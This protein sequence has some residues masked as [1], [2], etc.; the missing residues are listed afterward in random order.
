MK[1]PV[2]AILP[3]RNEP[4]TIA[5]VT[6]AVDA[7]LDDERAVIV[8]A[9]SSDAPDTAEAF[10]AVPTRARTVALTGLPRGKGTQIRHAV[11]RVRPPGAVL[12]ADTDTR[13]PD[14]QVYRALVN[15][16]CTGDGC[17]I[18]DYPRHWYEGNLTSHLAR[19]LIAAVTGLD[20]PQPLAG[21][22][23]LS[24]AAVSAV[25]R[26]VNGL[27]PP[28]SQCV[29]GYGID[30][31]LLLSV[32]AAGESV[33]PVRLSRPKE[34]APSF[35]HLP[36]IFSQ[37]VPVLLSLTASWPLAPA[38]SPR[39]VVYRPD[40]RPLPQEQRSAMLAALDAFLP[41][42]GAGRFERASW[43]L[44]L[45]HA[46][47]AVSTG[48]PAHEAAD[49]LWPHYVH[50]VRTWL[51]DGSRAPSERRAQQLAD[52]HLRL[53]AALRPDLFRKPAS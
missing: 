9:D 46:W 37:A 27:E 51:A 43:P 45:A 23:A 6:A 4:A 14:P 5:A 17:A 20:V 28:L 2:T 30:A 21:D 19:P 47:R 3:S 7:A 50:H 41:T 40:D 39:P 18:A 13:R 49:R 15:H 34:H 42:G 12:I 35:G 24:Q 11:E 1:P 31:F 10:A 38:P 25:G 22:L 44:P 52:A 26:A 16:A 8:H 36:P 33:V 29:D 53:S 48:T 32:A